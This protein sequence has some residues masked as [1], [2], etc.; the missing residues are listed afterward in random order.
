MAVTV[1]M[2][3]A[4]VLAINV[5]VN[6]SPNTFQIPAAATPSWMP[7]VPATNPAF[8]PAPPI[9]GILGI[10]TNCVVLTPVDAPSPFIAKIVLSNS[11]MWFSIQIYVFFLTYETCSWLVLNSGMQV[12]LGSTYSEARLAML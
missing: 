5:N 1:N 11:V 7:G 3:N 2:F 9:A 6:N 4:D 10:G 12:S 8:N